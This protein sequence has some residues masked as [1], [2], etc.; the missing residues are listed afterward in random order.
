[1]PI[2]W[3]VLQSEYAESYKVLGMTFDPAFLKVLRTKV[4]G[5]WLV[6][7]L[8][9]NGQEG[10]SVAFYPDPDHVWDGKSER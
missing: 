7:V 8:G 2:I 10:R 6:V 5:G 9:I 4:P 1:M 3:D